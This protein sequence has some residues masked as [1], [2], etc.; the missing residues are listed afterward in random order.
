MNYAATGVGSVLHLTGA[1]FL[2]RA[3]LEM[4]YLPY[5]GAAQAL[6][7]VVSG[8]VDMMVEAGA[9]LNTAIKAG[10]LRPIGV[11]S[12]QRMPSFPDVPAIAEAVPGFSS[13]GFYMMVTSSKAPPAAVRDINAAMRKVLAKPELVARF[14]ELGNEIRDVPLEALPAYLRQDRERWA[15]VVQRL[16]LKAN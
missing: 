2:N 1:L 4:T 3:G 9:G 8:R 7:D 15:P 12:A 10:Q 13:V 16:N 14:R 5:P 6:P 11:S